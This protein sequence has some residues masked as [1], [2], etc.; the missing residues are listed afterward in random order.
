VVKA[1]RVLAQGTPAELAAAGNDPGVRFSSRADLDTA[2]MTE[3]LGVAVIEETS[4]SYRIEVAPSPRLTAALA[5]W[6]A[7]HDAALT[8]LRTTASLE[9]T[10]LSL[11]GPSLLDP[12]PPEPGDHEELPGRPPPRRRGRGPR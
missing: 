6:L 8:E 11:V 1:G 9:E 12:T 10:Y 3:A 2:A 7:E 4:G 5:T